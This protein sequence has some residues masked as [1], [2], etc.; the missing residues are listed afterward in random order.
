MAR[1]STRRLGVTLLVA[2]TVV[3]TTFRAAN[4]QVPEMDYT[5]VTDERL[6]TP[7]DADWLMYRGTYNSWGYSA[8]DQITTDNVSR[9]VP[10][11]SLST[12]VVRASVAADRQRRGHVRHH[13]RRPGPGDRRAHG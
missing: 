8:L 13:P 10:V 3:A 7:D 11:W 4:A 9:L 2:V 5:P 1:L 6:R 12:G